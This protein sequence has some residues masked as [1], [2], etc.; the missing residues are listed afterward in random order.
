M[1]KS[2][3]L[4]SEVFTAAL[5]NCAQ[6]HTLIAAACAD[7]K[8]YLCDIR[9]GKSIW[10]LEGKFFPSFFL[11]LLIVSQ[12]LGHL[13]RV[14]DAKWSPG[15]QFA[16]ASS[17]EDGTIRLWDI[18]KAK[19]YLL[20]YDQLLDSK[21]QSQPTFRNPN[22]IRSHNGAVNGLCFTPDAT[23]L[24]STGADNVMRCWSVFDG[25][26]DFIHFQGVKNQ[27][28]KWNKT[29][30]LT[31]SSDGQLVFCPSDTS[32]AI[33]EI[34]TGELV[35][36]LKYHF[37]HV[38]SCVYHPDLQHLYSAGG[39]LQI[40]TCVPSGDEPLDDADGSDEDDNWS[41]EEELDG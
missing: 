38:N 24:L 27:Y 3:D 36:S 12:R 34:G 2:F 18:R 8:V 1:I 13:G 22:Q 17:S 28:R 29:T 26:N 32:V 23:K 4:E 35:N 9:T 6:D 20:T 31:V 10:K 25:S 15:H 33:Y 7:G 41:V 16:L 11:P 40:T 30:F 14:L 19:Q 5:S 21:G 37:V 39:D